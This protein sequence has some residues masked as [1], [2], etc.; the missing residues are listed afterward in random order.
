MLVV[1]MILV[2][3]SKMEPDI[4][5]RKARRARRKGK[6]VYTLTMVYSTVH[7]YQSNGQ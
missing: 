6:P 4:G 1:E 2:V 3:R 5:S 7:S